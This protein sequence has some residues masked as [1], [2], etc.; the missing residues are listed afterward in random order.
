MSEAK[1]HARH[2]EIALQ[3]RFQMQAHLDHP[4][5]IRSGSSLCF[6]E[7]RPQLTQLV[8]GSLIRCVW[9][10]QHSTE[11]VALTYLWEWPPNRDVSES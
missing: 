4:A 3:F 1:M 9:D 10:L 6:L 5:I 2:Y 11:H 7:L 8:A